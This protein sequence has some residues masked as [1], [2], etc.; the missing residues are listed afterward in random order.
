MSDNQYKGLDKGIDACMIW[1]SS[2]ADQMGKIVE[3]CRITDTIFS[4]D[5]RFT[6]DAPLPTRAGFAAEELHAETF[7]FDAILKN[8]DVR[9]FTDRTPG[10]PLSTNDPTNDIVITS[11]GKVVKGAQLKFYR[12]GQATANA[13]RETRDGAV[14]YDKT[15]SMVAPSD[16]LEDVR[17]AAEMTAKRNETVRPQVSKAAKAVQ[18]KATDKLSHDGVES[19][20]L[21]RSEARTAAG[22]GKKAEELRKSIQDKYKTKSTLQQTG[23][24]AGTAAVVASVVAGTVNTIH[25]MRQVREGKMREDEA[26]K[27][28]LKNTAIAACDAALKAG[29]ATAAV[30]IT[31]RNVPQLFA[32]SM[33][34][35]NLAKGSVAGAAICAV[36]LA[37][38]LVK[39]AAGKMTWRELEERTGKNVLQTTAGVIGSSIGAT[40]GA[41]GGP[42]GAAIGGFV[43]GMITSVAATVAIE[44]HIEKP[45]KETMANTQLLVESGQ[46]MKLAVE[47]LAAVD[48][49][50]RDFRVGLAA[51]ERDFDRGTRINRTK[52]A[53]NWAK[54][55][56]MK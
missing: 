53:S 50:M 7:N 52:I 47:Y 23:K 24:A 46:T 56:S 12:N 22:H 26:V 55:N 51:S 15:D 1:P 2:A 3:Q 8:K 45:F 18:E 39:V 27:Y 25:C 49:A 35:S 37:Q 11:G 31:A 38:G 10:T 30:S 29:A 33:L 36:D 54:I 6:G 5:G 21:T 16:Q 19:E 44:N 43:G 20:P 48:A 40:L 28:I 13:F 14:Y 34:Q 4:T 32:G 42:V 9:A 17:T 41:A